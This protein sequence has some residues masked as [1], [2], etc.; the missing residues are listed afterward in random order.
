MMKKSEAYLVWV[1]VRDTRRIT[2]MDRCTGTG[3]GTGKGTG[4]GRVGEAYLR[5]TTL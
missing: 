4:T 3:T 5:Y 1:R 2:L